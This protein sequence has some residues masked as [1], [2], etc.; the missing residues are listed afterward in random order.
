[1][2]MFNYPPSASGLARA[3]SH[4]LGD[5]AAGA[6]TGAGLEGFKRLLQALAV[7]KQPNATCFDLAA[8]APGDVPKGQ[9]F[10]GSQGSVACSDWSGCGPGSSPQVH[11][12]TRCFSRRCVAVLLL[13][14][15]AVAAVA[16]RRLCGGTGCVQ[17]RCVGDSA[18][19]LLFLCCLMY[20]CAVP[21]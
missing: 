8:Q 21:L 20:M 6:G 10:A 12:L 18:T 13:S 16:L 2:A 4:V 19:L 3:C 17:P 1:M 15:V 9:G 14:L 11:N 5:D 7:A